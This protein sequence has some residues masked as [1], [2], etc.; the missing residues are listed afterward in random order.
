MMAVVNIGF[1][2]SITYIPIGVATSIEFV[3]PLSVAA[4]YLIR[5]KW[6]RIVWA[7]AA[8]V[9][10]L[11]L[12]TGGLSQDRSFAD[13]TTA[14]VRGTIWALVAAVGWGSYVVLMKRT[15]SMFSGLEGL[16]ISLAAATVVSAPFALIGGGHGLSADAIAFALIL[17]IFVPLLPYTLE[18]IA[19]RQM[20]TR[21]FG[22]LMSVE[23]VISVVIGW[24]V[25]GQLLTMSQFAGVALVTIAMLRVTQLRSDAV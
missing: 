24:V 3:G 13:W 4:Y 6:T 11:L 18:M 17:A 10:V 23:P 1:Y 7:L 16:A 5:V 8:A 9:G 19:L 15:G 25:L 22:I 21:V 2:Q 14:D 12:T 20:H